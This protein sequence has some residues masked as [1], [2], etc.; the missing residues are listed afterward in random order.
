M[1]LK[2]VYII[3]LLIIYS[4]CYADIRFKTIKKKEY[5]DIIYW[6]KGKTY[7]AANIKPNCELE[8]ILIPTDSKIRTTLYYNATDK[9]WY[10]CNY[11]VCEYDDGAVVKGW[12][13]IHVKSRNDIKRISERDYKKLIND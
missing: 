1:K 7:V 8:Y 6:Y 10:E 12:C 4:F 9:P 11:V 3:I 2:A 13:N 5:V